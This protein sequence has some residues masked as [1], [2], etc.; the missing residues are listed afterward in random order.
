MN[1]N[2]PQPQTD[3]TSPVEPATQTQSTDVQP[4]EPEVATSQPVQA[5]AQTDIAGDPVTDTLA[6]PEPIAQASAD[7]VNSP[8]P[9]DQPA[10]AAFAPVTT[11]TA[12]VPVQPPNGNK[13]RIT[14]I[15][16]I[17]GVVLLVVAAVLVYI[18]MTT[19]SKQDYAAAA[20]QYTQVSSDNSA[21]S[22]AVSRLSNAASDDD[23]E[24]N[25]A[26]TA[27]KTSKDS[28]VA[29]NEALGKLKAV[30][31]GK[32]GEL[33]KAFD[34]KLEAYL[35]YGDGLIESVNGLRPAMVTCGAISDSKD[36]AARV[37]A[38]K[39]CSEGLGKV[40]ELKNP[41]FN[42]LAATL[43]TQYADYA[44][45]YEKRAALSDP[46]GDQY[47]EYKKLRDQLYDIQ[48][49][50]RDASSTFSKE[51]NAKDDELS[52]KES[53]NALSDYLI[54]QQRS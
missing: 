50:I 46:F 10:A 14:I 22:S 21:L 42:T 20:T 39:A 47:E 2:T 31:V 52:V 23:A 16:A 3:A 25:E 9:T 12:P 43:K 44:V 33:Y 26:L 48:D 28:L 11:T 54:E 40:G 27:A 35:A 8:E 49:N 7:P 30:K 38:L 24:F 36:E 17:A 4:A 45:V 6:D 1:P 29:S 18:S 37:T 34:T 41:A 51:I 32:G 5:T 19:V 53:A 13:K 15:A